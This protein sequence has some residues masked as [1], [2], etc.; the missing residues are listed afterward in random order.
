MIMSASVPNVNAMFGNCVAQ[1]DQQPALS[2]SNS[3]YGFLGKVDFNDATGRW[4]L[5]FEVRSEE[6]MAL[7]ANRQ[8]VKASAPALDTLAFHVTEGLT[9]IVLDT[10]CSGKAEYLAEASWYSLVLA[11][12]GDPDLHVV[13]TLYDPD[14]DVDPKRDNHGQYRI[15]GAT[16]LFLPTMAGDSI[17]LVP[18]GQIGGMSS[19]AVPGAKRKIG[20]D[21]DYYSGNISAVAKKTRTAA[22]APLPISGSIGVMDV[23]Q[24]N[25]NLMAD[26]TFQPIFYYDTGYP[27]W[28]YLSSLPDNMRAGNPAWQGPIVAPTLSVVLSHWDWDHWRLARIVPD[29]AALPWTHPD[30]PVGPT[31]AAFL[32]GLP[33]ATVIGAGNPQV[34]HGPDGVTLVRCTPPA[35]MAAAALMNNSGLALVTTLTLPVAA[36]YVGGAVLTADASF[37]SL[38]PN[39]ANNVTGITAVHHGSNTHGAAENLP[40]VPPG[41]GSGRLAYSC[42][43]SATTGNRPY[44]F[45]NP[46]AIQAYHNA[47]WGNNGNDGMSTAEG[48]QIRVPPP[49]PVVRGNIRMG[50]QTPLPDAYQNTAFYPISHALT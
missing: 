9:N 7:V 39:I 43:V 31:T 10:L 13:G 42:G 50:P 19:M 18:P 2:P 23:G 21:T 45:P 5:F 36:G 6:L 41:A 11:P 40:V 34:F 3:Y 8:P 37:A 24:G 29:L 47:H 20:L 30:Q 1:S 46:D 49:P 22:A 27:L 14:L 25:C 32:A 26:R 15:A 12:G 33:H 28:F 38:P 35:A 16:L 44:N 48:T 4:D 17:R